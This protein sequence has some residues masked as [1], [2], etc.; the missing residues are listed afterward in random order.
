M[1]KKHWIQAV[2]SNDEYSSDEELIAHF[3]NEGN[4]TEREAKKW[5]SKRKFY[6]NN[7]VMLD[8]TVY[9]PRIR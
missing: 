1:T 6:L 2:L 9:T 7:I 8:G 4:M 5:V 3:M